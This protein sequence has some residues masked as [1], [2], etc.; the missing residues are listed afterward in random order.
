MTK[1][2]N[3]ITF[4][5]WLPFTLALIII[6]SISAWYYPSKQKEYI[7][8]NKQK[9]V[10][11][12]AV[13]LAHN[14]ESAQ[15]NYT[16][17]TQVLMRVKDII[18]FVRKDNK[19]DF[20]EII[21]NGQLQHRYLRDTSS[22]VVDD[23]ASRFLYGEAKFKYNDESGEQINGKVRVAFEK[24]SIEEEI[25]NLNR[26]IYF[27]LFGAGLFFSMAFY[28][29]ARWLSKPII[30]LT[31]S[32]RALKEQNY[33][34]DLPDYK[35]DDEIGMLI[36]SIND[37]KDNL[38][39]QKAK[40]DKF[41][42]GLEELVDQRAKDLK[43][44]QAQMALAQKNAKFGTIQYSF[45]DDIWTS[46]EE[47]DLILGVGKKTTKNLEGLKALYKEEEE[48]YLENVWNEM[49]AEK[50][51]NHT[52][53]FKI[54][55]VSDG[56]L[57][58]INQVI[59]IKFEGDQPIELIGSIQDI[60]ERT[61]IEEEVQRLSHVATKTTN[62]VIITDAHEKIVWVN[63]ATVKMTEYS[64]EEIIGNTPRMF[65]S[66]KTDPK[67]KM[68]IRDKL[69][70][71][72]T[73]S[74]VEILN[75]SK[76]GREYWLSLN[77]VPI[78]DADDNITGYIAIESDLT[79]HKRQLHLIEENEK[80]YRTLLDSSSEMIHRLNEKGQIEYA[81]KAWLENMGFDDILEVKGRPIMEFF[82]DDTLKEFSIVTPKLMKGESVDELK[83]EFIS[84][85]GEVLNIKGRAQP[86]I[87]DGEFV[88][89]EAYLFNVTSVLKAEG[90]LGKMSDFQNLLMQ[91][92]TEYINAPVSK[93]NH[94]IN[95]SLAEIAD[96]SSADR[97]YVFRYDY[98]KEV[99]SITHEWTGKGIPS[100]ID[101]L[102]AMP[103][104]TV[105][106]SLSKHTAGDFVEFPDVSKVK[107]KRIHTVLSEEG[108]QSLISVPMMDGDV[109][110]GFIGFD[111]MKTKREFNTNEKNLMRLY[112]QMI[113]NVINRIQ[114]IEE[115]Q[116]TKDELSEINK[117]L[118]KKVLENTRKNIDLSRSILEQEKLVTIG[119][120]SAGIAHDLNTPL[121]T[122]RVA[123]DNVN[124]ILDK[125]F[126]DDL[127]DFSRK[128]LIEIVDFVKKN[129]IEIYVGGIQMRKEKIKMETFLTEK[130]SEISDDKRQKYVELF[131]KCRISE[132]QPELIETIIQ[133]ENGIKY[134]GV[135]NQVQLAFAQL[136]TIKT[137]SDKAVRVV[138]DM[139]AFIK[140]ETTVERKMINLRDNIS[141]VLGVFNYE[142]NLNVDLKYEVD[143][144][145]EFMGYD[146]KL[147][148]LWS[149]IV[150]NALEAMSEQQDKYLGIIAEKDDSKIVVTFENNGPKIPDEII[151]TIFNKFYTTKA[152]KSGSGLGLSIVKNVLKEH[153]ADIHI[154][155]SDV[156]TKFVITFHLK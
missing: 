6:I 138:Q 58:T 81:N 68:L 45:A 5:I 74:E 21:E 90:D 154:E 146:I 130:F 7:I 100:Q 89:S 115:L 85:T 14:Y 46:S 47:F 80:N 101:E 132:T 42:F 75:V 137:S 108:I 72:E 125:L 22:N 106:Y 54:K 34:A 120:I 111:I 62:L 39:E 38:I 27:V 128:E 20:I 122:I 88:G 29:F 8:N 10:S 25:S 87:K 113:V 3:S 76:S 150:K 86:V 147:F 143:E 121:G 56:Q 70:K 31:S 19:I 15:S 43:E 144:S 136:D 77:I 131:V 156:L 73:I 65:Q 114:F 69:A 79:D 153:K 151:Q 23:I 9:Q 127:S 110:I 141:T 91:I 64:R 41:V 126:R 35:S 155:S 67:T 116:Y 99:C 96:F 49:I 1:F 107:D 16:N 28:F 103:F 11:E 135:L 24:K 129:K 32:A 50:K 13:G 61:K 118:E 78:K 82:T 83:C 66:K 123:S 145:I 71:H 59:E 134:L 37:L 95:Q 140:G 93:I 124:F 30:L 102:T 142:I 4:K 57:I 98:E 112:A 92:S 105:P 109:A 148:Q 12:L 33:S 133:K 18:E 52:S 117:S 40:N 104:E 17:Y 2:F 26:P 44:T 84:Q 48:G 94:L 55:R 97:A 119:E 149:N 139:R 63:D 36:H 60:S 51:K 152:K 53:D